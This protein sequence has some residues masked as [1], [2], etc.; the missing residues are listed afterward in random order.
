FRIG[1]DKQ[2]AS[3]R[4]SGLLA[5]SDKLHDLQFLLLA[6]IEEMTPED[7]RHAGMR[8]DINIALHYLAVRKALVSTVSHGFG[9]MDFYTRNA[10]L[11]PQPNQ[12]RRF[13]CEG[14]QAAVILLE[15]RADEGITR[16]EV[17]GHRL[18]SRLVYP[19]HH[20]LS[21]VVPEFADGECRP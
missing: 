5:E 18:A 1:L 17:E 2:A 3:A 7:A 10:H 12:A 20:L 6:L 21:G 14:L 19:I 11:R 9:V 15:C 4:Y 13:T 8:Q 16:R